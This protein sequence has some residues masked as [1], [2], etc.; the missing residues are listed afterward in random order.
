MPQPHAP[1]AAPYPALLRALPAAAVVLGADGAVAAWNPAAEAWFGVPEARALGSGGARVLPAPH[2]WQP[3][4]AAAAAAG[5]SGSTGPV[6]VGERW[7][8]LAVSPLPADAGGGVLLLGSDVTASVVARMEAEA[9][10]DLT[11]AT[12]S[13][14]EPERILAAV[15]E[16]ARALLAADFARADLP[17][18]EGRAAV[19]GG[20]EAWAALR[21]A[22]P[23]LLRRVRETGEA[24][25]IGGPVPAGD[26]VGPHQ[27]LPAP[28]GVGAALALPLVVDGGVGGVLVL[29]WHRS[30]ALTPAALRLAG[31][32][33]GQAAVAFH[34]AALFTALKE[35]AIR[36][37]RFFSAMSHD[38]RTPITAI[39]G[40]SELLGDGIVGELDEK[41]REMVERISQVAGHLSQ[42]VNDILDLAK[43]D[44]GR[45]EFVRE[46]VPLAAL[47]E[48]AVVT[49]RP[50]AAAKSLSLR[51]EL[52]EHQGAAVFVDP[53]RVRQILVNLL[54]NAVKF[55][56]AGGVTV[57][58][59]IG[60]EHGWIAVRDTG[61]GLPSGSEE[62]VFEEFLQI[63]SGN[64]AKRE[65]GSGLGLAISRRLARGMGGDLSAVNAPGGGAVFTLAL[66][67][68]P[69][70]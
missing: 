54:S 20:E 3:L 41:Q 19:L 33:A 8:D 58:A 27:V 17:L 56:E 21:E 51:V 5:A 14:L 15:C 57:S 22:H 42:L 38:L 49:I 53:S 39:V 50:Q 65:P 62:V 59:G 45:M 68:S 52:D 25:V 69:E 31:A 23:A 55:T 37:E 61:P 26:E 4:V 63:A 34:H 7:V 13:T 30:G 18:L 70:R 24:L 29:G 32:L 46:E 66:P 9:V 43:L 48:E 64:K 11:A 28:A 44:A 36:R 47:V 35:S 1:S 10:R 16:H 12:A 60:G 40:Y 2:R 6:A 67:V